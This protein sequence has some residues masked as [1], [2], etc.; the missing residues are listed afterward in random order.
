MNAVPV[1]L[2]RTARRELWWLPVVALLCALAMLGYITLIL[3]PHQVAASAARGVP[4]GNLS[5][6]YPRW[7]GTR[8]LLQ[9]G[10]NPYSAEVTRE[11]QIGYYGVALTPDSPIKD[12]QGFAYPLYVVFLLAPLTL[13]PFD[14]VQPLFGWALLGLTALSVPLWLRAVGW[15]QPRPA[16]GAAVLLAAGSRPALQGWALEQLTLLVAALLA[17]AAACL[18]V[19]DGGW[20]VGVG[21]A[22]SNDP[23]PL[24]DPKLPTPHPPSPIPQLLAGALLAV[25]TSKPQVTALLVAG[26]AVW[27]LGHWRA[28]QGLAWGFLGTLAVLLAG[29]FLLLP[30]WLGDFRAA[31]AAYQQYTDGHSLLWIWAD[32]GLGRLLPAG[33]EPVT[34]ALAAGLVALALGVWWRTRRAAAGTFPFAR[35]LALTLAITL[36]IIP[37]WAPYNQPVLLPAILLLVQYRAALWAAGRRWVRWAWVAAAAM[38]GWPWLAAAGLLLALPIA[39]ATGQGCCDSAVY[40]LDFLPLLTSLFTPLAVLAALA[41]LWTRGRPVAEAAHD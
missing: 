31:L 32:V 24:P 25:A 10:R 22:R 29:A 35:A 21:S 26:L 41:G 8:E 7:L 39:A 38:I 30:G 23:A 40:R 27:V 36:L 1:P 12:Q 3:I 14:V 20:G 13:F 9:H 37:T 18:T 4:R 5:D 2:A 15:T 17:A 33:V 6:L 16:L 28:R 19:G 34:N 11:I